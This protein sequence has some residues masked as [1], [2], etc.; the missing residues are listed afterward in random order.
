MNKYDPFRR[1]GQTAEDIDTR[2]QLPKRRVFATFD[3]ENTGTFEVE[4]GEGVITIVRTA[5]G[6]YTVNMYP[7]IGEDYTV[8]ATASDRL[9]ASVDERTPSSFRVRTETV[10][11]VLTDAGEIHI[12]VLI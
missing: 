3:G 10:G 7:V 1:S 9:T 12:Y 6:T 2:I 11:G 4:Y 5:A 8:L